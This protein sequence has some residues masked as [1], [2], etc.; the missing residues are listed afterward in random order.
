[1]IRRTEKREIDIKGDDI[2]TKQR[3]AY[4]IMTV[5]LV[6]RGLLPH[7]QWMDD[8]E[9]LLHINTKLKGWDFCL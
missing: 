9:F 1:M 6:V 8:Y 5:G 2:C 7:V 4:T 3:D